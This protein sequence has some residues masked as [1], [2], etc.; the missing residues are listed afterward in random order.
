MYF[1]ENYGFV[2]WLGFVVVCVDVVVVF[3]MG[4]GCCDGDVVVVCV[5]V[6]WLFVCVGFCVGGVLFVLV[7]LGVGFL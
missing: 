4:Y 6:D 7:D 2:V 3:V 5:C 1:G